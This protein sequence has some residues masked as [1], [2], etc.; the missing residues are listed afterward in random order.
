MAYFIGLVSGSLL[1]VTL[2]LRV[3]VLRLGCF[4]S[5]EVV[6]PVQASSLIV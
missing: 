5:L 6:A 3:H 1:S 2:C 4:V